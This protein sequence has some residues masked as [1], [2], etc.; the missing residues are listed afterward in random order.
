MIEW[1]IALRETVGRRVVL[2]TGDMEEIQ[3]DDPTFES[4][5]HFTPG[6]LE[7]GE[8]RFG[9]HDFERT[10]CCHPEIRH[11]NLG[12]TLVIHRERVN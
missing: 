9:V 7:G 8:Y 4:D 1:V 11:R 12:R 3:A 10:C 2:V 5:V 6:Y